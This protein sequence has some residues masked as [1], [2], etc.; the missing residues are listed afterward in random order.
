M[1]WCDLLGDHWSVIHGGVWFCCVCKPV[2][3]W[4]RNKVCIHSVMVCWVGLVT[5]CACRMSSYHYSFVKLND[6]C[7]FCFFG[8]YCRKVLVLTTT[9]TTA[10]C[11]AIALHVFFVWFVWKKKICK[12]C[13]KA[14]LQCVNVHHYSLS[15]IYA[16]CD[17]IQGITT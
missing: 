11:K 1:G 6:F 7:L 16:G 4:E 13:Y 9:T 12:E 14:L 5:C 10:F 3:F 2:C 15:W 17:M 8:M